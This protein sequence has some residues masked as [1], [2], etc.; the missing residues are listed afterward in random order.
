MST[1]ESPEP[2]ADDDGSITE[3]SGS[4]YENLF[5]GHVLPIVKFRRV[6]EGEY[7]P[8]AMAGT[9]FTFGEYTLVTCWHCVSGELA[10]GEVYGVAYRSEGLDQQRYDSVSELVDLEQVGERDL[11]L[12]RI[13]I[14]VE[15]R[16]TLAEEPAAWGEDVIACGYPLPR[17]VS[18]GPS[19]RMRFESNAAMLKGYV[20]RLR[21]DDRPG[22]RP[23]RAYELDMPAP[24]GVSGS[25]LFRPYPLEVVGVV[26][27]EQ[28]ITVPD[29]ERVIG[30]AYAHHLTTLRAARGM[31]TDNIP[32]AEYLAR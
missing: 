3:E 16:L 7:D 22:W 20:T 9:G 23:A 24:P 8:V 5:V 15:P 13:G 25:P 1:P 30:F 27:R 32:L 4:R 2:L 21:L 18:D 12:A 19:P 11:A 28:D 31:A 17:G 26:Y 14:A 29:S 6:A 10:E